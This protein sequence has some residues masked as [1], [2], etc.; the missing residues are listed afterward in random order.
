MPITINPH[1]KIAEP[2][3]PL[4]SGVNCRWKE[5]FWKSSTTV[6]AWAKRV[7]NINLTGW[8]PLLLVYARSSISLASCAHSVPV[9]Y[10]L[11]SSGE[12]L[13]RMVYSFLQFNQQCPLCHK[14]EG[15]GGCLCQDPHPKSTS[16]ETSVLYLRTSS[17]HFRSGA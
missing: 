16:L 6:P 5:D 12:R 3:I 9:T 2:S 1:Y 14:S 8:S 13:G 17:N 11:G 7:D 15:G 4:I 10:K